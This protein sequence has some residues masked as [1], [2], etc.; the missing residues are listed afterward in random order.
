MKILCLLFSLFCGLFATAAGPVPEV[1]EEAQKVPVLMYHSVCGYH[2]NDYV[3]KPEKFESDLAFL[4]DAGY[5]TVSFAQLWAYMAGEGDLPEKCVAVTFDDG[6]LNNL[7]IALPIAERYG[8]KCEI[9]VVGSFVEPEDS[10][11][12]SDVYSY[13]RRSEIKS[14]SESG[15]FEIGNH[16]YDMHRRG[17]RAGVQQL[18]YESDLEYAKA[19]TTDSEKCR[20]LIREAC[21]VETDIFALPYGYYSKSTARILGELGYRFV[22]TCEEGVNT[23]RKGES[24]GASGPKL[25]RRY[26]RPNRMTSAQYFHKI[27]IC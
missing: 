25:V 2:P 5:E 23:F 10:A 21:G 9:N 14:L 11:D 26:N 27:G 17:K 24:A 8:V 18:R 1:G 12:R 3:L 16:T 4:R 7:D 20:D 15:R 22:L 13:L 6:C 19:L